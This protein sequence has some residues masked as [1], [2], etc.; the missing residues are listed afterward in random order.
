MMNAAGRL[1]SHHGCGAG[2]QISGS[3]HLKFSEQDFSVWPFRSEPF[4]SGRSG[5]VVSVTGHFGQTMSVRFFTRH[6]V[7]RC[8]AK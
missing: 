2:I 4:R 7:L 8:R 5:L 1:G 3:E 6:K